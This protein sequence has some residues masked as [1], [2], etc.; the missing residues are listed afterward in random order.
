MNQFWNK[1]Y[2]SANYVYGVEP[3]VF[4][5]ASIE[6]YVNSGTI[7]FPGEGEGRNAVYAAQK[8]LSVT[9]FD[10]SE[11]GKIKA[12]KLAAE[13]G[14]NIDYRV[15]DLT[16]MN[17]PKASFDAAA[18]IYAHLQPDIRKLIH[19]S[20][21]G[22][23]KP[24]GIV[25]LEGFSKSHIENQKINPHAG[26]PRDIK[27]LYDRE[28]IINDFSEFEPLLIT[29]TEVFLEEGTGHNGKAAVVRFVGRKK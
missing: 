14:V 1:K 3:N 21:S 9:A 5:K 7:L 20:L 2:A 4:L 18:L 26:G 22:F 6:K 8:G 27:M 23:I 19:N 24:G 17:F 12:L 15:G 25:I 28:L 16:R 11:Q 13:A 10:Q 29:E